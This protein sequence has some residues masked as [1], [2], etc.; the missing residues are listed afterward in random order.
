MPLRIAFGY[1]PVPNNTESPQDPGTLAQSRGSFY[2]Q[3]SDMQE[4]RLP[5]D[6][7]SALWLPAAVADMLHACP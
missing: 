7:L 1:W 5:R 6:S 2:S 3:T 4:F